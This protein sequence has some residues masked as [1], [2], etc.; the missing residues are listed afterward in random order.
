MRDIK[1]I[2]V[3]CA[4]TPPSMDI[5]ADVIRGWHVN[6]RGFQDIGYHYVI[7]RDGTL[8][9]GRNIRIAGAHCRGHNFTS[10]GVCLVGGVNDD[11]KAEDN[12]TDAQKNTLRSLLD[13][14]TVT[15]KCEVHGHRDMRG[16]N[17]ACPSFDV[18]EWFYATAHTV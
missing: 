2:L 13:V 10:I 7:K 12:F 11:G 5:G 16:V 14:L 4:A 1:K 3:H 18:K 15:F 8:E 9:P 17:K 6:E